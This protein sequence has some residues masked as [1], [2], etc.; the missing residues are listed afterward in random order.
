MIFK[1]IILS[2]RHLML[3]LRAGKIF[4]NETRHWRSKT[5]TLSKKSRRDRVLNVP[6]PSCCSRHLFL[7][8]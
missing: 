7:W 8:L 2:E 3:F 5:E 4:E 1:G 6:K